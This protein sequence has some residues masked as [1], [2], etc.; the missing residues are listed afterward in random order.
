MPVG[1]C[2]LISDCYMA[3]MSTRLWRFWYIILASESSGSRMDRSI[4]AVG[5]MFCFGLRQYW[6]PSL[7]WVSWS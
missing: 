3:A 4:M 7:Y 6:A 1:A 5:A 2:R